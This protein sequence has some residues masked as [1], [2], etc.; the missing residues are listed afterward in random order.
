MPRYK[1][2]KIERPFGL[3]VLQKLMDRVPLV[4]RSGYTVEFIQGLLALHYWVPFRRSEIVGDSGHKWKV[5]K[6]DENG[7]IIPNEFV[8]RTSEPFPGLLKENV[9]VDGDYVFFMQIARKHGHREAPIARPLSLPHMNL[10]KDQWDKTEPGHRIFP[11]DDVVMWRIFKRID[12]KLCSHAFLF[13]R[14]TKQSMDPKTSM[15]DIVQETGKD[16]KTIA[17]YMARAGRDSR[18][19]GDRLKEER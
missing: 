19:I 2:G 15:Q 9:W 18:P 5:A 4:D 7:H 3:D 10:I 13:N 6:R 12:P 1:H 11:I 8:V 14:I 16:P 17:W